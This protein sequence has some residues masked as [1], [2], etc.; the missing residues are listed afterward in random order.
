MTTQQ[1]AIRLLEDSNIAT[2]DRW[3][4]S[5]GFNIADDMRDTSRIDCE[6]LDIAYLSDRG[7]RVAI[8]S[9]QGRHRDG[10]ARHLESLARYLKHRLR[11]PVTYFPE[12][13]SHAAVAHSRSMAPGDVTLFGNTRHHAGEESNCST[14][15]RNFA[16]LGNFVAI[17][18]FS[19]AHRRHAS[20]TGILDYRPGWA[21]RSL[22]NEIDKLKSWSGARTDVRTIAVLGGT[23]PEKTLLGLNCFAQNYDVVVPGGVVLHH[24]L[25]HSGYDIGS[26]SVGERAEEC[27]EALAHAV[28]DPTARI[29]LPSRVLIARRGDDGFIGHREIPV[30]SGVPSGFAIVDFRLEPWLLNE[31]QQLKVSGGRILIAGTPNLHSYGFRDASDP[32]LNVIC[33]PGIEAILL[34]GDTVSELRF[35]GPT[36][37]GGGSALQYLKDA[38]LPVLHAL[39]ANAATWSA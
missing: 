6:I 7:A 20:N 4:F 29:H 8:L 21:A 37:T 17:G 31:L 12:N 19:K 16:R 3:I 1:T 30:S 23:K 2:G 9:H 18:G 35:N 5:A 26:S 15:A 27:A 10:S 28:R 33:H 14:L 13:A 11:R 25:R 34:G 39:R 32:F 36:S 22:I 24:M 38:D